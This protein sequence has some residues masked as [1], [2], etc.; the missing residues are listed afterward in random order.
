MLNTVIISFGVSPTVEVPLE[1][2]VAKGFPFVEWK[3]VC[4]YSADGSSLRRSVEDRTD[5]L[6]FREDNHIHGA[7]MVVS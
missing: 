5:I 1:N 2:A 6:H 3:S 7:S 4:L